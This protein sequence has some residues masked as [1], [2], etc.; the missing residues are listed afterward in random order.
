VPALARGDAER[1]LRFVAATATSRPAREPFTPDLLVELGRLVSADFVCYGGHED[2]GRVYVTRPGESDEE[3]GIAGLPDFS[4]IE[5]VC[6]EEDPMLRQWL[7]GSH[8]TLMYSDFL[9]LRQLRRTRMHAEILRP[10]EVDRRIGVPVANR[11]TAVWFERRRRDFDERDRL[12]LDLLQPHLGRLYRA[13][14][15]RRRTVPADAR[16]TARETEVLGL[17]AE[18]RTNVEIARALWVSPATV[19][20]HLENVFAK[21][22]VHTRTA[23]A[24][25]FLALVDAGEEA[26]RA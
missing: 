24:A 4:E 25:R 8:E 10:Y 13:A 3:L 21:L 14:R 15:M 9:T 20:K 11:T 26:E 1:L 22:G 12:V 16:L 17:A 7:Q 2:D 5:L 23:A 6:R 18:G 19:R